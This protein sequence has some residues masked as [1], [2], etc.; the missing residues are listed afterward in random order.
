[1]NETRFQ[2]QLIIVKCVC[3]FI[4]G[5]CLALVSGLAQWATGGEYPSVIA[6]VVIIA[7][8]IAN[9]FGKLND[10]LSTAFG[11][12]LQ[13]RKSNGDATPSKP[14]TPTTSLPVP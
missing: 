1:M 12:Y 5:I 13:S 3:V 8:A 11:S 4:V 7:S 14:P 2:S 9:G 6:W 10:F